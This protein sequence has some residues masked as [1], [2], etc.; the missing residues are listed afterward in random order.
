[1][2]KDNWDSP[3]WLASGKDASNWKKKGW[4]KKPNP[5]AK[6]LR[7]MGK[8]QVIPPKK[9][10]GA[11]YKRDK[12]G[13]FSTD[14]V[15]WQTV[16]EDDKLPSL[17]NLADDE[18]DWSSPQWGDAEFKEEEHDRDQSGKFTG[19]G[20]GKPPFEK[21][22]QHTDYF[23]RHLTDASRKYLRSIIANHEQ[24]MFAGNHSV[25]KML[26]EGGYIETV[27]HKGQHYR[28]RPTEKG[29]AAEPGIKSKGPRPAG[30]NPWAERAKKSGLFTPKKAEDSAIALDSAREHAL[31][32]AERLIIASSRAA[33][34]PRMAF[35]K[36]LVTVHWP[37]LAMD[38]TSVRTFSPD[39]HLHVAL[40]NISRASVNPYFGKEIP[41]SEKLGLDP[42]RKY[43]LL[44]HPDELRKAAQTFNGIPVLIDHKPISADDHPQNLVVGTTGT[45]AR[46]EHPFLQNSLHIWAKPAIDA[47]QNNE[48]RELSC[49][50]HYVPLMQ[51]GVYEGK[52][53]DGIMSGIHG[54]HVALVE[55]GRVGPAAIV[56]DS[57]PVAWRISRQN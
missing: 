27:E 3:S 13:K 26:E 21:G 55:S 11:P 28:L 16:T 34:H 38:Q 4:E 48:R 44:R 24:Q 33:H 51:P 19:G 56:A 35:D 14:S 31:A 45:D 6:S 54:N 43:M 39:G 5:V 29:L 8:S 17:G 1:M 7:R 25:R 36:A 10:T 20:A 52:T 47:I 22:G 50:Y 32:L 42:N 18:E 15:P 46:Y 37:R 30:P 53:F 23:G 40:S 2:T 41:D 9:G 49:A 12:S 57:M